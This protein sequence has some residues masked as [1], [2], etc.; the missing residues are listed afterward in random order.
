MSLNL[1][2]DLKTIDFQSPLIILKEQTKVL[3]DLTKNLLSCKLNSINTKVKGKLAIN[4]SIIANSYSYSLFDLICVLE[5]YP[6]DLIDNADNLVKCSNEE[7][8]LIALKNILSSPETKKV[9]HKLLHY[10]K[11]TEQAQ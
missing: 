5:F 2:G 1:W 6:I 4:F 8:F 11:T 7:E 3:E 10:I 9:I